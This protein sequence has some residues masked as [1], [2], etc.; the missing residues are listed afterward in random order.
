MRLRHIEVFH[1]VYTAGSITAAARQ[2]GVS[3]P[4][5]SKVL[6]H[7]E[8]QLGYRLFD[9][10]RGKLFP[11]REAERL[12]G[13]V[14]VVYQGIDEVQRVASNL[15][16]IDQKKIRIAMTP[17]FGIRLVPGALTRFLSEQPDIRFEVETLHYHQV[18]RALNQSRIDMG[19]VFHPTPML[20]VIVEP[21][22]QARFVAVAHESHGLGRRRSVRLAD[23]LGRPFIGLS[24]RGP[25]G[26]LLQ[27]HL[28]S[29]EEQFKP[30]IV[31]E[32]YQMAMALVA[33][34]AGVA[35]IDEIT[36]RSVGGAGVSIMQLEP[37]IHFDIALLR[38]GNHALARPAEEFVAY[39]KEQ[40]LAFLREGQP[41]HA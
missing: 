23:L 12:I 27:E 36:A 11:T 20:D 33:Q 30:L 3:Q 29:L 16:A 24:V 7:A 28:S 25:L 41:G 17:A 8:Q 34:G 1:A 13:L 32:T 6:A 15:A 14:S 4:S 19:V 10:V 31:V 26:Q 22:A 18:V 39:L 37:P 40:V 2:L 9:R 21:L 38:A 5:V 35:I